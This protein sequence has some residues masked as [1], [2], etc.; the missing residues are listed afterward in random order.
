MWDDMPEPHEKFT[1]ARRSFE[2]ARETLLAKYVSPDVTEDDL[3]RAA[4][5]GMLEH[6][7]PSK[8]KW[9]R[10]LSPTEVT[11]LHANLKGEIVGIGVRI[12]NFDP[13]TGYTDVAGTIPGSPADRAG[14]QKGDVIVTVDGKLYKGSTLRDVVYAIRG[15]VGDSVT[16]SVLRGDK[17]LE[18]PLTRA[19][20]TFD[21]VDSISLPDGVGY[22][23]IRE[24]SS[25]APT[26]VH[27][28]LADLAAKGARSLVLDL[29]HDPGGA[30][31]DALA[32]AN[33]LL[34]AGTPVVTVK[35]R[36]GK[37]VTSASKAAAPPTL[38]DAPLVILIDGETASSAELLTAALQEGRHATTVGTH[39]YGKWTV[40]SI[41]DLSNGYA[42]KYTTGVFT[43]PAGRS[44]EGT[45]LAP[46]VEVDMDGSTVEK[47][48][49]VTDPAERLTQ[50]AQLRTAVAMAKRL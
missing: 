26:S 23:H 50:D 15:K 44:F 47:I 25:H 8:K 29:R 28:A 27:A 37:P 10:L 18:V 36:D 12:E 13:A 48:M 42:M 46:D 19:V 4:V 31:E 11:E 3:Y 14:M 6:V 5:Q 9:N 17:L 45:G 34:P 2:S 43:S 41:D 24:F 33:E 32:T 49:L 40:Q 20:V 39:T 35:G 21:P 30:F 38:G 1:D 16:L 7:D 22:L